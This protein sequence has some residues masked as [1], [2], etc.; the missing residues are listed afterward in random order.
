MTNKERKFRYRKVKV[1]EEKDE[2]I[3]EEKGGR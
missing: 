2:W 3:K 1:I